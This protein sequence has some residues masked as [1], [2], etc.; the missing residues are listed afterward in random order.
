[1]D[2]LRRI[3]S[4]R[5]RTDVTTTNNNNNDGAGFWFRQVLTYTPS[6]KK[7]V[8][9][10]RVHSPWYVRDNGFWFNLYF[11]FVGRFWTIK[12]HNANCFS[13]IDVSRG[14]YGFFFTKW[15]VVVDKFPSLAPQQQCWRRGATP[16][17]WYDA[18]DVTLCR[19]H[20]LLLTNIEEFNLLEHVS[21]LLA[22]R[23]GH[24]RTVSA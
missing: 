18:Q 8:Y 2:Y 15:E 9:L 4:S 11:G 7:N 3:L 20:S 24:G 22:T 17:T 16:V 6:R 23:M 10:G 14:W 1:M 19:K 12:N 13:W 5:R 21:M